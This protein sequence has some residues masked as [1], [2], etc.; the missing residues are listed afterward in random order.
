MSQVIS[1]SVQNVFCCKKKIQVCYKKGIMIQIK[2]YLTI[3][4]KRYEKVTPVKVTKHNI[5]PRA[6]IKKR[7]TISIDNI[8]PIILIF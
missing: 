5:V 7:A 1:P 3:S 8:V 2:R 4:V 6:P